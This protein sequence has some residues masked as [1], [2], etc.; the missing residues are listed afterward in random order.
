MILNL[1]RTEDLSVEDMIKRSF[2]EFATQRALGARNLPALFERVTRQ[3]RGLFG[4]DCWMGL[5]DMGLGWIWIRL[6]MGLD[7]ARSV[8]FCGF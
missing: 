5:H 1:L 6:D 8:F 7:W 2:S 3:V 4:W